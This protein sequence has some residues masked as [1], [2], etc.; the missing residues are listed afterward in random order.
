MMH[1]PSDD[2]TSSSH[3][4]EDGAESIV[5]GSTARETIK[6]GATKRMSQESEGSVGNDMS[7]EQKDAEQ[8]KTL[9]EIPQEYLDL[10]DEKEEPKPVTMLE[11]RPSKEQQNEELKEQ[12]LTAPDDTETLETEQSASVEEEARELAKKEQAER[13]EFQ[14]RVYEGTST[15]FPKERLSTDYT[16]VIDMFITQE[17]LR[18]L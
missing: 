11:R 7:F 1:S 9:L 6:M 16:A 14:R 13:T 10:E 17:K 12:Q 8:A 4:F 5:A 18:A 3:L 2:D 15:A